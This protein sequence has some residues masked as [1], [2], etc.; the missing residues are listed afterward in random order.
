M[1][2]KRRATMDE[3]LLDRPGSSGDLPD[4]IPAESRG[5]ALSISHLNATD[6]SD[7]SVE[8]EDLEST[9]DQQ[10][11][12]LKHKL[13]SLFGHPLKRVRTFKDSESPTSGRQ[14]A[15]SESSTDSDLDAVVAAQD[16]I[17]SEASSA[18]YDLAAVQHRIMTLEET[19][20]QVAALSKELAAQTETIRKYKAEVDVL[21]TE[22]KI[23]HEKDRAQTVEMN[24]LRTANT[25]LS[26][27]ESVS[28][29]GK[30]A[31]GKRAQDTNSTPNN[32]NETL[33][34]VH[35]MPP[36]ESR[37]LKVPRTV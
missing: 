13:S 21:K 12:R 9:D 14:R 26:K 24:K 27:K 20:D 1:A 6:G 10:S 18:L 3:T 28:Q 33:S 2:R 23:A 5:R 31:S 22:L 19:A 7:S 25:L 37:P 11:W 8:C 32:S 15:L 30:R 29:S 35:S 16:V 36:P 34:P 17:D 4:S